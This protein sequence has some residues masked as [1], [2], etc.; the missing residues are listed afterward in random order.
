[1][2]AWGCLNEGDGWCQ[3]G[4]MGELCLRTQW[5]IEQ[6]WDF[7]IIFVINEI[8]RFQQYSE[9]FGRSESFVYSSID[10]YKTERSELLSAIENRHK[11]KN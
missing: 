7:L 4:C 9:W 6:Y 11:R 8:E 1:M 3:K 5:I 10:R 2:G